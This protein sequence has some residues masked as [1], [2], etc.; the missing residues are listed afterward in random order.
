MPAPAGPTSSATSWV[1]SWFP[2]TALVS[3]L[4]LACLG[5]Q[6]V[7]HRK[8]GTRGFLARIVVGRD[9]HLHAHPVFFGR[10]GNLGPFLIA[11]TARLEVAAVDRRG[12]AQTHRTQVDFQRRF[13]IADD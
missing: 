6:Q 12:R 7:R 5:A 10:E 9:T 1:P 11:R 4:R 8:A 3:S 13:Y 2:C